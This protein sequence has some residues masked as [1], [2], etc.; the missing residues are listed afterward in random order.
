MI[1]CP[2]VV[3]RLNRDGDRVRAFVRRVRVIHARARI[4]AELGGPTLMTGIRRDDAEASLEAGVRKR[5]R[6]APD[7]RRDGAVI[8]ASALIQ[9]SSAPCRRQTQ[10]EARL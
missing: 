8:A 3:P 9:K 4:D 7:S 1:R 10:F 2:P 5:S 6:I